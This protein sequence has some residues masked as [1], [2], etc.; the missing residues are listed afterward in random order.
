LSQEI[1]VGRITNFRTGY[2]TQQP[3]ECL[4]EF[5]N[6]EAGRLIGKKV[7][8]SNGKAKS[9]GIIIGLHGRTSTTHMVK[10][11]FRKPVPAQA[12]GTDVKIM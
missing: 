12:I 11:R 6:T 10:A 3:K 4:I 7:V 1:I 8:W 2:N 5:L 9:I